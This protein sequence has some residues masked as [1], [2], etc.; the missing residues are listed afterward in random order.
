MNF[1]KT[2]SFAQN[3]NFYAK[4]VISN[5]PKLTVSAQ[6]QTIESLFLPYFFLVTK[7]SNWGTNINKIKI[8]NLKIDNWCIVFR[9]I[10]LCV[11]L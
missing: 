4:Y 9:G 11:K 2:E 3:V 7:S 1:C 5:R 8:R 10:N 6:N